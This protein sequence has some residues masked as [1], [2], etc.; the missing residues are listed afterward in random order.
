MLTRTLYRSSAREGKTASTRPVVV[1]QTPVDDEHVLRGMVDQH[2]LRLHVAMHDATTVGI[3]QTLGERKAY[4]QDLVEVIAQ[5][6]IRELWIELLTLNEH[7]IRI[8][9]SPLSPPTS[10]QCYRHESPDSSPFLITICYR[11]RQV[12]TGMI[13]GPFDNCC[14]ILTSLES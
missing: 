5:L 3:I 13:K 6:Q 8:R 12:R 1:R 2:V 10:S 7:Q 4:H 9:G 14:I 11:Q